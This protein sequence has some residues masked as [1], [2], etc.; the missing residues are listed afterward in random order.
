[1]KEIERW[2]WKC[3]KMTKQKVIAASRYKFGEDK[4]Y[5]LSR[6]L[7]CKTEHNGAEENWVL[8]KVWE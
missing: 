2:C 3:H 7:S 1:M 4:S 8:E 5:I 6:C